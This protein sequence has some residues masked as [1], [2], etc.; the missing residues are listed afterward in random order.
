MNPYE[1]KARTKKVRRICRAVRNLGASIHS[2]PWQLAYWIDRADKDVRASVVQLAKVKTPSP[3]TWRR[4]IVALRV[5][6]VAS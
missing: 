5:Y 3:E 1:K 4:V 6:K 2:E